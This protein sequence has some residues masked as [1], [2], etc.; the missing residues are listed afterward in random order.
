LREARTLLK[1]LIAAEAESLRPALGALRTA[2]KKSELD[3]EHLEQVALGALRP[4]G[5][6][7]TP[8]PVLAS[9]NASAYFGSIGVRLAAGD[10]AHLA[11]IVAALPQANSAKLD[12]GSSKSNRKRPLARPGERR[13]IL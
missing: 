3:A 11:L 10:E 7:E 6:P 9:A 4:V 2:I 13:S 12:R 8:S 1:R 5:K